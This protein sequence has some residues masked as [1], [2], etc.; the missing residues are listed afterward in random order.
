MT[1]T[2]DRE[3]LQCHSDIFEERSFRHDSCRT[4]VSNEAN[5][6]SRTDNEETK[7]LYGDLIGIMNCDK[8]AQ[9]SDSQ[10]ILPYL[11]PSTKGIYKLHP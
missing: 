10:V 3:R 5:C 2:M 8:C 9:S 7:V 1:R 4:P 11:H 6:D